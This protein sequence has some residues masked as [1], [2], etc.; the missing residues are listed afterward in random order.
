MKKNV[1]FSTRG[2]R[3]D[4]GDLLIYRMLPNR[5]AQ[6]VGP[7][8][9]LDHI[10]P[11]VH[12]PT[13]SRMQTGTGA[14]PHRGIATLTYLLHG[15]GEH[16][17]SAGHHAKVTSGGIQWMKAGNGVIHDETLNPNPAE[18]TGL[19]H[20]MQFWI[21]LPSQHKAE[22]PAYLAVQAAEV[23]QKM[24]EN[25]KGWIKVIAGSYEELA[26]PIPSYSEQFLYHLHLEPGQTFK[27]ETSAGV[28]YA[29]FLLAGNAQ[30]NGTEHTAN[31]FVEFDRSEGSV[32]ITNP[33]ETAID[34][35]LFGGER[36][37]E[38]IVAEG[39]FVMNSKAEI[40]LAYRDFFNGKY[41]QIEYNKPVLV[42]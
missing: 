27:Q 38:P 6:A 10:T 40:A 4:I 17:D 13:E 12:A 15:K 23:P 5:Y 25:G 35:I 29:A 14:H 28:E 21:N 31:E 42:K 34:V 2:Q 36:Y 22:A 39:P 7:F 8:V 9:F 26:S 11:K 16:F 20:A 41:G 19:T 37:A 32:E 33:Q 1:S 18:T 30:L 24:L 3:A